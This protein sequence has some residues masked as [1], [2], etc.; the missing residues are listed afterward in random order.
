MP[1]GQLLTYASKQATEQARPVLASLAALR[2]LW[3][4]PASRPDRLG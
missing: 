1:D 2:I 3:G 4:V